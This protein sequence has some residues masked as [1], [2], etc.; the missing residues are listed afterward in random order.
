MWVDFPARTLLIPEINPANLPEVD[1]ALSG[2]AAADVTG[3][4]KS[5]VHAMLRLVEEEPGLVVSIFSG[6]APGDVEKALS[7]EDLGTQ[8]T[9]G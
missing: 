3:G 4:M 1:S 7:G 8:I 2:S 5:K 6:D 9:A